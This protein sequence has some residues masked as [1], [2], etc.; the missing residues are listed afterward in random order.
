MMEEGIA[1]A[2]EKL[3]RPLTLDQNRHYEVWSDCYIQ[4]GMRFKRTTLERVNPQGP[5]PARPERLTIQ[6]IRQEVVWRG[7]P[8]W[9]QRGWLF[10]MDTHLP[11]DL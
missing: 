7:K 8:F 1:R 2:L 3:S 11:V 5:V 4:D 10:D 9:S 6:D